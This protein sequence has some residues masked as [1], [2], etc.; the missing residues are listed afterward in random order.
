M[1]KRGCLV[2]T[3]LKLLQNQDSRNPM[4]EFEY[5]QEVEYCEKTNNPR[6]CPIIVEFLTFYRV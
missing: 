1:S 4:N 6:Y 2:L 5:D 3:S